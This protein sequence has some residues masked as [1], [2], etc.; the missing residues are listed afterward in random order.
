M[1][2]ALGG[3]IA[4]DD[5]C[6]RLDYSANN[7]SNT[8]TTI[9]LSVYIRSSAGYN[10]SA[11]G[12]G[13]LTCGSSSSTSSGKAWAKGVDTLM[14]SKSY[15]ITRTHSAQSVTV[16]GAVWST[17]A[18]YN[19]ATSTA[20]ATVTVPAKPSYAV[21][22]SA[23]GGS[24]AP[25][26]QT[27]W[28]GETLTLSTTKPT[29]SGYNFL[30]WATSKTATSANSSYAPGKSYTANAALTLY[31]VWQQ[32]S[33]AV[34][35]N[36]NGSTGGSTS[37]QTKV[38]GTALTLRSNGFTRTG[39]TF[40][41]WNTKAD[42]SGTNYAAGA[43]YTTNA[44]LTL[45]AQWTKTTYSVAYNAN[46]GTGAPSSQTKTYGTALT[47]SSTRPTWEGRTFVGWGTSA[48]ATSVAYAPGASYTS[49]AAVTLYAIW[50]VTVS[51]DANGGTGAPSS[52]TKY[53]HTDLTLSTSRPT[54]AGGW[55]FVRWTDGVASYSPGAMYTGTSSLALSAVWSASEP[56]MQIVN[57]TR[58]SFD[59][60]ESAWVL[61]EE[62]TA[63]RVIVS[64]STSAQVAG[65][66]TWQ[67]T[68]NGVTQATPSTGGTSSDT[69]ATFYVQANMAQ[70]SAYTVTV[71]MTDNGG[72][73]DRVG[74]VTRVDSITIAYFPMDVI[75]GGHGVAFGKP[76]THE[77]LMDVGY[78]LNVDGDVS[79]SSM[80]LGNVLA[81][82]SGG[83]GHTSLQATRN[84]MGLGNTTGVLPV[85]NGGTGNANGTVA[86]LTTP[87]TLYTAL[88]NVYDSSN[89]VQFDGSAARSLPIQGT[90]AVAH[91][92]TGGTTAATARANIG[93][94]SR[95][96]TSLGS[97]TGTTALTIDLSSYYEVCVVARYSTT[98]LGSIVL[99]KGALHA[100]TER[101][102]YLGGWGN[103]SSSSNRRAV[104]QMTQAKLTPVSLVTDGTEH[105]SSATW[106]V[107]AR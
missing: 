21:T 74:M 14:L 5:Y 32:A 99:P 81:P 37:S 20:S 67:V 96:W 4:S 101:E 48:T 13:K 41:R 62:G 35:Y 49:N 72:S 1:T 63:A 50:T 12:Y 83:T 75:V 36:G 9:S 23:N 34:T 80:T 58:V 16:K 18:A 105:E 10:N 38:N 28:Y 33:Y 86:K 107:Y 8:A 61:D 22:Y 76:A 44:A 103:N 45:Y 53:A 104:A 6:A 87:R 93:A 100:T 11:S 79:A 56:T 7:S 106:T 3:W 91:G 43:S 26:A 19:S 42:G 25:S 54:R 55:Q 47:L 71:T 97:T 64:Y 90:L 2:T 29:R 89:P 15:S 84:A 66:P 102:I 65:N 59:E 98:Y 27:K 73:V 88:G 30:G 46:G 92:G 95:S 31:A 24:G 85:A 68:V 69:T 77:E 39:Y 57:S 60:E 52:Q 78:D 17:A 51:Y 40:V 70:T 94:A 82:E